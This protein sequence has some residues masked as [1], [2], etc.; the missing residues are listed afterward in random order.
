MLKYPISTILWLSKITIKDKI[1]DIFKLNDNIQIYV[2]LTVKDRNGKIIKHHKQRSHSFVANFLNFIAN[3]FANPF[4]NNNVVFTMSNVDNTSVISKAPLYADDSS[5]DDTYGIVVGTGTTAPTPQDYTLANKIPNGTS[6]GQLLYGSHSFNPSS[7][8]VAISGNT[9]SFKISR[10]FTNQSGTSITVSEV[11]IISSIYNG[12][13]SQDYVLII[14][15][16]LSSPITI[17]NLSVLEITYTL[18]I[19]T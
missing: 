9:S 8:S 1:K 15:D 19:T 4:G 18:S 12:S 11:G 7:G 10:T 16:L 13:D 2:E 5:N 3:G 6:N 17:A 14:H